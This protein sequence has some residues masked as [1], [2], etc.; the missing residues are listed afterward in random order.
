MGDFMGLDDLMT[1]HPCRI[2]EMIDRSGTQPAPR[3]LLL[4]H[5][6]PAVR[7]ALPR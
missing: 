3:R 2:A 4:N 5:S 1:E 7:S 6:A